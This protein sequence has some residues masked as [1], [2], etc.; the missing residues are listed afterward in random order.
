ME[1]DDKYLMLYRPIYL[2]KT[3]VFNIYKVNLIKAEEYAN[4]TIYLLKIQ[5]I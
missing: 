5:A 1:I 2:L 3:Q 4:R